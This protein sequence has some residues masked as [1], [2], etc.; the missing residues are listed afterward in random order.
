MT[1]S[2]ATR[3]CHSLLFGLILS[4][5]AIAADND[6]ANRSESFVIPDW[7]KAS[8]L[9]LSEDNL[10][11]Q[12]AGKHLMVLFTQDFCPYCEALIN[13]NLTQQSIR[14][15]LKTNFD[16]VQLNMWQ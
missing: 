7:F 3:Q 2:V 16:I 5:F 10:E 13:K 8:F 15:S 12:D 1:R 11:A 6:T 4:S 14:D 9:D